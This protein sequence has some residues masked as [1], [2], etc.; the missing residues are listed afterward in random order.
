MIIGIDFD[1][2][3]VCYDGLFYKVA[4]DQG[5]I[6][7][8]LDTSKDSVRDYLRSVGREDDWT[9]LQGL[10]YGS[11]IVEAD[12]FPGV[13]DFFRRCI[14]NGIPVFIVSHKTR[15]PYLGDKV[16]LHDSARLWLEVQ[17][18]F[19]KDMMGLSRDN[20]FFELT[21][22]EKLSRIA[23]IGCTHFF[24][25]LPELLGHVDFSKDVK[26]ILFDPNGR[27]KIPEGLEKVGSWKEFSRMVLENS[28]DS[29]KEEVAALL[30]R[31]GLLPE[32]SA[33]GL[34]LCRLDGGKNNK[35]FRVSAGDDD[36]MLKVYFR[37][38]KD[39]RD[40]QGNEFRFLEHAWSQGVRNTHE[41]L[42][43]D[44]ALG[45]SVFRY[46]KGRRAGPK[47]VI[48]ENV[49]A[50]LKFF[51]QVNKGIPDRMSDASEACFSISQHLAAVQSRV[52]RLSAMTESS[53][54]HRMA[55]AFVRDRLVP[56]WDRIRQGVAGQLVGEGIDPDQVLDDRDRCI[57]PSDFG[58][59]NAVIGDDGKIAFI[60]FEYAGWD[61][62]A[63][64]VCDF[65][66]QPEL[67][68]PMEFYGSFSEN[69]FQDTSDPVLHAARARMLVPVYRIKWCCIM[70]N[71]FLKEDHA[72]R[73]FALGD[74]DDYLESQ[75][76]KVERYFHDKVR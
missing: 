63:K 62:P 36:F 11:R 73:E 3:I 35:V 72:R 57:S 69:V 2:T 43:C 37:S 17:G 50:A 53:P 29:L 30:S 70:L 40:R 24:D 49:D 74:A 25:D 67:P 45:M 22:E 28:A 51:L 65:F 33:E 42:F 21:K 66:S 5:L 48:A 6:P 10:V 39:L 68:L 60:D 12:P 8:D 76:G 1:N 47:D 54:V 7:S 9:R 61:D 16:D 4:R 26:R 41:P 34:S 38:P 14:K 23:S 20:V 46:L 27:H 75:L 13:K 58:F 19:D 59:H 15:F 52:D 31:G 71:E 32:S 56:T 55:A 44:T 64:M 18:F